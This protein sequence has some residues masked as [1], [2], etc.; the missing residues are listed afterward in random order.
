MV[1]KHINL[2]AILSCIILCVTIISC[3]RI[4]PSETEQ[5]YRRSFNEKKE[6][7]SGTV[8]K[9][10]H[11]FKEIVET[12]VNP[13]EVPQELIQKYGMSFNEKRK[14]VGLSLLTE[15]FELTVAE[16]YDNDKK[17][18]GVVW[19]RNKPLPLRKSIHIA[20]DSIITESDVYESREQYVT[21]DCTLNK[22]LVITYDF[23]EKSIKYKYTDMI[24]DTTD[25]RFYRTVNR[26]VTKQEA[27]SVIASW[28]YKIE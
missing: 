26:E 12:I 4:K 18:C 20:N 21:I 23:K 9:Y 13:K 24:K 22:D 14:E 28:G 8:N 2:A 17:N 10:G 25:I 7:T 15:D 11:I 1:R 19:R 6:R 5:R 16:F 27:D 3:S